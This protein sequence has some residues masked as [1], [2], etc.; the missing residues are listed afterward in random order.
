MAFNILLLGVTKK[1]GNDNAVVGKTAFISIQQDAGLEYYWPVHRATW[2]NSSTAQIKAD[3]NTD[4]AEIYAEAVANNAR[5]LDL[6][7][8]ALPG[9]MVQAISAISRQ[10]TNQE[11]NRINAIVNGL[12]TATTLAEVRNAAATLSALPTYGAQD[13][14]QELRNWLDTNI[15]T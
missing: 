5:E 11:R 13:D 10:R 15:D 2:A 9:R 14:K 12:A 4:A 7:N 1:L 8:D 3:L 6:F